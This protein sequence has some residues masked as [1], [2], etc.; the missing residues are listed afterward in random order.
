LLASPDRLKGLVLFF[1][2]T[3]TIASEAAV[4]KSPPT[5]SSKLKRKLAAAVEKVAE[6]ESGGFAEGEKGIP[7]FIRPIDEYQRLL[8]QGEGSGKKRKE[9]K[10]PTFLKQAY[11]ALTR[12]EFSKAISFGTKVQKDPLFGDYGYWIS[13]VSHLE[14]AKE[15]QEKKK[16]GLA[17]TSASA[18]TSLVLRI[19]E[20]Y[21]SSPFLKQVPKLLAESDRWVGNSACSQ[22]R[23]KR[24]REFFEK[25]FL[26]LHF[27]KG[28]SALEASELGLYAE[29]CK[30]DATP[31]CVSWLEKLSGTYSKKSK[32]HKAVSAPYQEL[33][34]KGYGL[35]LKLPKTGGGVK[36]APYKAPDLDLTAFDSAMRMY[37]ERSYSKAAKSFKQFLDEFPRSIHRLRARF[38]LAQALKRSGEKEEAN[39]VFLEL[40]QDSAMSFYGLMAANETGQTVESFFPAHLPLAFD[41]DPALQPIERYHLER[42]KALIRQK[43]EPL[44]LFELKEI[45]PRE[46]FSSYFLV[47]LTLVNQMARNYPTSFQ[48]LGELIQRRFD[49]IVSSYG[50]RLVF[51]VE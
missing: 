37:F 18:V 19:E 20:L 39:K 48:A 38:W 43:A 7:S 27:L 47:Y 26:R 5:P 14:Q 16:Y 1:L 46:A 36:S 30:K 8:Q 40:E 42:A 24:C 34:G 11:E 35:K 13:A 45:K 32:E 28:L 25:T 6:S 22:K 12:K 21:P 15:W 49:G 4:R 41:D 17:G 51:Q 10:K 2:L 9:Q 23:W 44:A 3:L 50:L 33:I 29:G 31:T